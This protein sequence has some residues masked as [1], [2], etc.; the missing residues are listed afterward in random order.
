MR[1]QT[2]IGIAVWLALTLV[3]GC[4]FVAEHAAPRKQAS[5]ER[6][7]EARQA[8]E[9]FWR[10]LHGADYEHIAVA[11]NAETAAYLANPNDDQTAA[12]VAWL[13]IWRVAERA[14]MSPM[15]ATV[16]D[17]IALA[18][19]YFQEAVDLNPHDARYLGFLASATLAEGGIH[20]DER[21]TR[22]GYYLLKDAIRAYP[23]FNLF[24]GGYVMSGLPAQSAGY[25]EALE[26]QWRNLDVCAGE[27]V[28]RLHPDFGKY[29][30]LQVHTGPKRVCWDSEIAPHN[31][32]GFFLNMGDMLVKA[33]DW[34][35]AVIIYQNARLSPAYSEWFYRSELEERIRTAQVNVERFN[36]TAPD[37]ALPMMFAST[38]ACM[39]CHRR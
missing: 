23:E 20:H 12:H 30:S 36:A 5:T 3:A 16:T 24:T 1:K 9:L 38:F 7:P 21:L 39:A 13:H 28:D 4:A 35:T 34:H 17:D 11:L 26:W 25:H 37:R 18:R 29:L 14:R 32:E 15:P 19:R 10:T 31:F 2:V 6:S 22:R 8:D 33:G 27:K